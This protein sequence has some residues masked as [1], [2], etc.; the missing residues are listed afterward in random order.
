MS[1]NDSLVNTFEWMTSINYLG[2]LY[3]I[4]LLT[5]GA[6]IAMVVRKTVL[7]VMARFAP[8]EIAGTVSKIIYYAI[9][10]IFGVSAI[11]MLG[12]DLTGFVLAGGIIGIIL[13]F[14]LQSITA[15][16]VSGIFLFWERPLKPGDFIEIDNVIGR[17]VEINFMSTKIIDLKGV[18]I[19]IPNEKVFQAIIRNYSGTVARV[20]ELVVGIAYKED[21]MKA[22]KVIRR[23]VEEHP[24]VLVEPQPDIFVYQLGNS[25]VDIK[26]RAWVP[27]KMYYTVLKDLLWR[28]KEALRKEGIEIP[29]PQNDIWFR[30]PLEV[31]V[32]YE[33]EKRV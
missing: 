28:I 30:S 27:S 22:Y 9:L 29:F 21:V 33:K 13:G 11:G 4:I 1:E 14:A 2:I 8:K 17:V 24:L 19:R 12:I 15:N 23:V 3:A 31:V 7:R 6:V 25:S 32:R 16:L 5:I 18:L 26:I 10:V 20:L